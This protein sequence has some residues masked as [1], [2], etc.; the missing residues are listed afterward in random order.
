ME[1]IL[2]ITESNFDG[3]EGYIVLTDKQTIKVGVSSGQEC[4]EEFGYLQ[5]EDDI[6]YFVGSN[7]I[8]IGLTDKAYNNIIFKVEE[9]GI[10]EGGAIFVNFSTDRGLFQLAVYNEHNGYYSHYIIIESQQLNLKTEI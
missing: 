7:L 3:Y 2:S 4:C 10:Y 5:S 8:S 1:K 6:E 9:I